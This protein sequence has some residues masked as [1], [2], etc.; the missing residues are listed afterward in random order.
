MR[1]LRPDLI[2]KPK[3]RLILAC[4]ECSETTEANYDGEHISTK[5]LFAEGG[6]LLSAVGV[7]EVGMHGKEVVLAP[8]CGD[9]AKRA[10]SPE[11]LEAAKKAFT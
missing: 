4:V 5:L 7:R 3:M 9:C 6:W 1:K 10:Y 8:L 2:P 11:M